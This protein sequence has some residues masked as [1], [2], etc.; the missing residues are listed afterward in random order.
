[1]FDSLLRVNIVTGVVIWSC[2]ALSAAALVYLL[3]RRPA[4]RYL[5]LTAGA[6][7]VGGLS[8][9]LIWFVAIR[10]LNLFGT[11]LGLPV[12]LWLAAT[13]AGVCLAVSSLWRSTTLRK[14]LAAAC[15][16]LFVVTGTLGV[17]AG[18]GLN[19]TLG[20]LLGISTEKTLA[21]PPPRSTPAT[22]APARPLWKSWTPPADLPAKGTTGSLAIPNTVSGFTSRPA[23]IYLPPAALVANP[24]ALPLVVLMMGQP[25]APDPSYIAESLDRLAA[26]NN[27]LAPI[28]I[29]AD[30]LGDPSIDPLCLDT[31]KYGNAET[32]LT[33]DVVN[34][35]LANLTIIHDPR[36]WTIAGYSNGGQCAISLFAKHP[37]LWSN[38]VD[39]SGEEFPGSEAVDAN[40]QEVFGGDTSAYEAQKPV[41]LLANRHFTDAAAV[42]TV[43]SNDTAF[44]PGVKRVAAA[45]A[46]AGLAVTYWES[47]NGGHV[48][49]AL[50]DGLDKAFDVLY[51]RLGLSASSTG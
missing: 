30:Q 27:G 20:S 28:V 49:P 47:P 25:G 46:A 41:N 17:N 51:P 5:A 33:Q 19:R 1:M 12:Y 2:F 18:F 9:V 35:A 38:V 8:A 43:G 7:I 48:L 42:F 23:G 37:K 36:Y 29:V 50:T 6:I 31:E 16:V 15:V 4:R 34:W 13:C 44:I 3:V 24:P 40:L 45:A 11:S 10:V 22:S 21:L 14:T 32:F 26:Q 39:I